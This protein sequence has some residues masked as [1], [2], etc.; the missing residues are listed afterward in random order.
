MNLDSKLSGCSIHR[1]DC[2]LLLPTLREQMM[3]NSGL[4]TWNCAQIIAGKNPVLSAGLQSHYGGF[5]HAHFLTS[6]G[7]RDTYVVNAR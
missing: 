2:D 6:R 1:P 3:Y 7:K 4:F 5:R